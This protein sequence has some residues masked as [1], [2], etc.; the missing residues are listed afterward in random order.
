MNAEVMP[1]NSSRRLPMQ[2]VQHHRHK[3]S[4][5]LLWVR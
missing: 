1:W 3:Q 2:S 5:N 4:L